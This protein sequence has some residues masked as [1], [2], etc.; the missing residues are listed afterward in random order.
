MSDRYRKTILLDRYHSSG[1][2]AGSD[3][4]YFGLALGVKAYSL[5]SIFLA[6]LFMMTF[7]H[8][9]TKPFPFLNPLVKGEGRD[10][11]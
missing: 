6:S 1:Y 5:W 7:S 2:M 8:K 3:S 4:G 9:S 10:V 11:V